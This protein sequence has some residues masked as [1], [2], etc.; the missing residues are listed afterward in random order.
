MAIGQKTL[1]VQ[2]LEHERREGTTDIMYCSEAVAN[3]LVAKNKDRYKILG[4]L[5]ES[6]KE[7]PKTRRE[8]A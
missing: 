3:K 5:K 2:D 6:E 4:E 1:K 7:A 8:T